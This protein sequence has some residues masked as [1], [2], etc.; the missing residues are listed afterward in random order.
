MT[1]DPAPDVWRYSE[2]VKARH[3]G[4]GRVQRS[5]NLYVSLR[6]P[7]HDDGNRVD[8]GLHGGGF[9]AWPTAECGH[10]SFR[11][12]GVLSSRTM[13]G[14]RIVQMVHQDLRISKIL[15]REA[16]VNAIR[17]NGAVGG[18]TNAV[19]HSIAMAGRIEVDLS[20]SDWD[21]LGRKVDT[22]VNLMPSGQYLMEDFYYAGG[23][24][25]RHPVAR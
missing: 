22:L 8:D 25:R 3:H 14:R 5:G 15:T 24:P 9:G 7:L 2:E 20:L 4:A 11:L 13:S 18:S 10:S 12:P 21:A 19:I 6:R 16:F 23:L 17:V 1:S